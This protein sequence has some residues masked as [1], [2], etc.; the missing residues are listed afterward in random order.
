M[1]SGLS[2]RE[3]KMSDL[4]KNPQ[5][6]GT[7][8]SPFDDGELYDMVFGGFDFDRE[9]YKRIA[10][11]AKGPVLEVACGTGRI[12]IPCLEAGVEIDGLDLYPSMLDSLRRKSSLL[13]LSPN[14][15]QG[16]MRNFSL[17]RRYALIFIAFNGFVHATTTE[18]QLHTLRTC[19]EHLVT[20][21]VLVFNTYYP[22]L[23]IIAGEEGRPVLEAEVAHPKTGLPVRIYDTRRFNRVEQIQYS[24]IEIQELDAE[25]RIAVSHHAETTMRW[26]YK[27]EM[28][29]LLQAAGFAQWKIA[30]GFDDRP[31][32]SETDLMVVHAW[33]G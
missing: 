23:A 29:L 31:L 2:C 30:G 6:E 16:D 25:G 5:S 12:L 9:Y 11:E 15:Y 21:G 14:L 18:D 20:D 3:Q 1:G 22:G 8:P 4:N 24:Q 27:P 32:L 26:T 7:R 33:N 17:P 28:E 13:E 10:R 19:R